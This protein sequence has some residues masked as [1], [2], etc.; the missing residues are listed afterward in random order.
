MLSNFRIGTRLALGFTVLVVFMAIIT[1]MAINCFS[2]IN[3]KVNVISKDK[4]P[5]TVMLHQIN[6]RINVAARAVRNA[7]L[8][9]NPSEVKKELACIGQTREE[10]TA[11]FGQ[12]EKVV[13]DNRGKELLHSI[14]ERRAAYV[15]EQQKI[16]NMIEAGNKAAASDALETKLRPAQTAYLDAV[17]TMIDYQ[18]S[19][20]ERAG[21]EVGR[22][23]KSAEIGIGVALLVAIALA[24]L[25]ALVITRS[26]AVPLNQLVGLNRCIADG[27]LGIS[28]AV[29]RRD[30]IGQLTES[31]KVMVE[32]LRGIITHLAETSSQVAAASSQLHSTA[33]QLATA[34][35]EVAGQ[36]STVA[37]AGE[38]MA[39]TSGDIARNC[40]LAAEGAKHAGSVATEG[41]IVVNNSVEV[42][43]RIARKVQLSAQTVESLGSRSDQIGEIVGTIE[44]IADQTNL[45][46][47]NAAIEAA[48]A[49][50]QGRG[51]AVVADEVRALAE[52]T[53]KATREIGEMIK[54]IQNE[55]RGAV[56]IMVEGVREVETGTAEAGR[57]GA[58]L[59]E[60]IEEIG[61]VTMQVSQIA[62]AAEQQTSTTTEISSNIHQMSEV[63]QQTARGA[64][65][66]SQAASDLSRLAEEL[67]T[68]VGKFNLQDARLS[69]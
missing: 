29:T 26:V 28:F 41:A 39:V 61:N 65:D 15:E 31:A 46:A 7:L 4:W 33:D 23:I 27:N 24:A 25:I 19:E 67:K 14:Q 22:A 66:S 42:M 50:E 18:G 60:I 48:R 54:N 21:D 38:E 43:E 13:P 49:G 30:E 37:T 6:D 52:R 53:T 2:R 34:S 5:K 11:I 12:L 64:Q 55:T 63:I 45:L 57:S 44:D 20:V 47:L 10:I 9:P 32:N 36:T 59:Q 16:V 68:I 51:F 3:G 40:N 69:G 58:A 1:F 17:K 8:F 35:Q 62:T 56:N